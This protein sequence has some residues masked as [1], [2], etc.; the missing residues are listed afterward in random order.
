MSVPGVA[1]GM[2]L[3]SLDRRALQALAKEHG[4]KANLS[5][6]RIIEELD[7][8]I[9]DGETAIPFSAEKFQSDSRNSLKN[10]CQLESAPEEKAF[11]EDA[12]TSIAKNS[13]SAFQPAS[14]PLGKVIETTEATFLA[15]SVLPFFS[16]GQG[17]LIRKRSLSPFIRGKG[18]SP[19][20]Q[21][22]SQ[23]SIRSDN[24]T[25][26][27]FEFKPK[28]MPD[29]KA[30]HARLPHLASRENQRVV[31]KGKDGTLFILLY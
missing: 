23:I 3:T 17:D 12:A 22:L 1:T 26:E 4:V 13:L 14:S 20:K 5:N 28:P 6:A 31:K 24:S 15:T 19:I 25:T 30:L 29:F 11:V 7:A 10:G 2:D 21:P 8:I 9:R 27:V 18:K 16:P